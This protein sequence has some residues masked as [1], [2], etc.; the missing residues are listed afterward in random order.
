MADKGKTDAEELTGAK[1]TLT[2][3]EGDAASWTEA[4]WNSAVKSGHTITVDGAKIE[5][6]T[7]D[8]KFKI[9]LPDGKYTLSESSTPEDYNPIEDITFDIVNGKIKGDSTDTVT[10]DTTN[11]AVTG[12]DEIKSSTPTPTPTDVK[13]SKKVMG[14]GTSEL[15][16]ATMMLS[17]TDADIDFSTLKHTGGANVYVSLD[18]K[19]ITWDTADKQFEIGLPNGTY[20]LTEETAP[21]GYKTITTTTFT[22]ENG[23]VTKTTTN[24]DVT[25]EGVVVT[26]FDE[27][28]TETDVS[29]SKKEMGG[30]SSELSGASMKLKVDSL[31]S[32]TSI[33]WTAAHKSGPAVTPNASG[34]E[35]T[36]TSGNAPVVLTLP[37]GTYILTEETAP[38]GYVKITET[39]FTVKGGKV[40]K[41]TSNNDVTV[42]GTVVTA[43]DAADGIPTPP[44]VAFSKKDMIARSSGR[45]S[46]L[47]G[48]TMV[49]STTDAGIDFT[50]LAYSGGSD[51]VAEE[52]SITWKTTTTQFKICL[53]DGKY[54]LEETI[55]PYGY[56]IITKAEFEVKDGKIVEPGTPLTSV[57]I[58]A[59][60]NLITAYDDAKYFEVKISKED[61]AHNQVAKATLSITSLDG[62]D[63]SKVKVS[64]NGTTITSKLSSDKHTISFVTGGNTYSMISG[65]RVG[66]YT[67]KETVTPEAYKTAD[68]I[69]FEITDDGN[70]KYNG[71][72][73]AIG[74]PIVMIDR[75]DPNYKKKKSK[76][77]AVPATG[78][79][80]STSNV[81]AGVLISVAVAAMGTCI[82]IFCKKKKE[83]Y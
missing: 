77:G 27:A 35:I 78:A 11:N 48:A 10:L 34:D 83:D 71:K 64:R 42:S 49:L 50:T 31:T 15:K 38:S 58:D 70:L 12:F 24:T 65:L 66:K 9:V 59:S 8:V 56:N 55:A 28:I 6:T 76:G 47:T 13:F 25:V 63:L 80:V 23:V 52:K 32:A 2:A 51:I 54:S 37:D 7:S 16:G 72:I 73:E 61:I 67:L 29:L 30:G 75:A 69:T 53:P 39:T 46:E 68:A 44:V 14:G 43:L 40:T 82:V 17:T 74:S 26:A 60:N 19:S 57:D 36:W 45:G 21:D 18:R 3:I 5:W 41:T 1:L 22:V 33:D 20:T 81:V 62:H 79:G 4:Q